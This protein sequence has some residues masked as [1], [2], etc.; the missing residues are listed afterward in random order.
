MINPRLSADTPKR[1]PNF[2]VDV[3]IFSF[4]MGVKLYI[5]QLPRDTTTRDLEKLF[6]NYGKIESTTAKGPFGFVELADERDAK[7]AVRDLDG[8]RFLGHR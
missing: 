8:T 3:Y 5:G 2:S 1:F 6:R 7:D 4:R